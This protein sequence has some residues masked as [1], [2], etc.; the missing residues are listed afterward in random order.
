VSYVT[1]RNISG[2]PLLL[3]LSP[4]ARRVDPDEVVRVEGTLAKDQPDDAVVIGEGDDARAY[5]T[6]LWS[7]VATGK[8]GD[9]DVA[10]PTSTE[11]K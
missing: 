6:S 10:A 1:L 3:G 11:E 9:P 4:G 2:E 5:P 7:K 8:T